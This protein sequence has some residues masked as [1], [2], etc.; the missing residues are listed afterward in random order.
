MNAGRYISN[1]ITTLTGL[2]S[3]VTVLGY[4][5][6]GGTPSATDRIIATRYGTAALNLIVKKDFGK[7]VALKKG[8]IETVDLAEVEGKLKLVTPKNKLVRSAKSI[9]T[10]FGEKE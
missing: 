7:M 1:V 4:I 10:S 2:E 3:R 6:R 8:K 9:G 5:Q